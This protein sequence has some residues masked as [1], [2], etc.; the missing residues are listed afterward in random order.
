MILNISLLSLINRLN[1]TIPIAI[2]NLV[3]IYSS[4]N[5]NNNLCNSK[6]SILEDKEV[7]VKIFFFNKED[8]NSKINITIYTIKHLQLEVIH[9]CLENQDLGN[10]KMFNNKVVLCLG[11]NFNKIKVFKCRM[12]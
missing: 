9:I 5:S 6:T 3:I 12:L 2:Y 10:N 11:S 4:I 1:K 7:L 8:S